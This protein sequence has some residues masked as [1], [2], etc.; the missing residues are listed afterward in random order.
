MNNPYTKKKSTQL[1][2]AISTARSQLLGK[3]LF[4]ELTATSDCK[5]YRCG[6]NIE[7]AEELSIDHKQPWLNQNNSVE[8]FFDLDNV[9]YSHRKCNSGARRCAMNVRADSGYKGV[10]AC[11]DANRKAKYK[12]VINA[13]DVKVHIGYFATAE[14]AAAEYDKVAVQK[15]GE[16]AVTNKMLG[17]I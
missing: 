11:K 15:L 4:R 5:C 6:K 3:L 13:K 9:A 17:L 2:M 14:E 8:L 7:T 10:V 1:G 16:R 12:A